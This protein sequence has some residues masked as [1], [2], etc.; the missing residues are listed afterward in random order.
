MFVWLGFAACSAAIV[1]T[2]VRLSRYGDVL[3]EK[4][5]MGR[6][7]VGVILMASVTSLPELV[8]GASAVTLFHV[9]DLAAGDIFGSCMFNLLI[10]S[11]LDVGGAT[12]LSSRIHQAHVLSASLGIL[13]IGMASL[14]VLAGAGAPVLGWIG[15]PSL[16]LL[17]VYALAMRLIFRFEQARRANEAQAELV[18]EQYGHLT[19]RQTTVR[20]ALN[21][22]VLV[23]AAVAL[24][25]LGDRI[26]RMTGLGDTFVG[27]VFVAIATSLPEMVISF[28]AVRIGALDL[29]VGNLF[30]SNLFNIAV[31]GVD[32]LLFVRG[33]FFGAISPTHIVPAIGALTMTGIAI[34]GLTFRATKRRFYWSWDAIGLASTYAATMILLASRHP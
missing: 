26:A 31:L 28:A 9:P 15:L 4:L 19:L 11:F 18:E 3:G 33:P 1:L 5:G 25:P 29:A 13:L 10:L 14:G 2:G 8:N 22:A 27:T 34:A 23:V 30:G 21:A 20:Y 12:P 17:A 24:P 7:W 16:A 32:D 6:T